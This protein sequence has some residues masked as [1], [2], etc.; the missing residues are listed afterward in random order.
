MIAQVSLKDLVIIKPMRVC[1][2]CGVD[3][4]HKQGGAK[5]C[6]DNHRIYTHRSALN[7]KYKYYIRN[8]EKRKLD[9][10]LTIEEFDTITSQPCYYC[11][12]NGLRNGIDR[13]D[14]N[15]GYIINN[16]LPCCTDHAFMRNRPHG[17]I[18]VSDFIKHCKSIAEFHK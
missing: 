5:F 13:I 7:P 18:P 16:C 6:S 12:A 1:G 9:F 3:I 10:T 17:D 2:Y 14:C 11:G 15:K 4:S 8:A